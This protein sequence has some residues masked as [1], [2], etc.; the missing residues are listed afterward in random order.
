M[1]GKISI[2]AHRGGK[3]RAPENT[4]LAFRTAMDDGADGFECDV[5]LTK[6]KEPVIIH[7]KFNSDDISE[8]VQYK[9]NI[10]LM[11][12]PELKKY[13]ILKSEENVP[14]LDDVLDFVQ[15]NDIKC[16]IEP[17]AMSF[18][19]INKIVKKISEANL[20]DKVYLITFFTRKRLLIHAKKINPQIKINVIIIWPLGNLEKVL[21][22]THSDI[23][24]FGWR[25][26]NLFSL[27]NKHFRFIENKIN[28][29]KKQRIKIHA[30]LANNKKDVRWCVKLNFDGIWTDDVVLVKN[31]INRYKG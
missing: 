14:H 4:M 12:W 16:F 18:E 30:G 2:I 28:Q 15:G 25:G 10:S 13:R 17:K 7:T 21:N 31:V 20:F 11:T 26:F 27:F 19:L 6:D 22:E 1:S 24:T 23:I 8:I 29:L 3:F 5:K 9:R